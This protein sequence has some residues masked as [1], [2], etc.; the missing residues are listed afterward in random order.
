VVL[1]SIPIR[2]VKKIDFCPRQWKAEEGRSDRIFPP[3]G[4]CKSTWTC[5]GGI[6]FEV[7]GCDCTEGGEKK[8]EKKQGKKQKTR[9]P[10]K[11]DR[12]EDAQ[13]IRSMFLLVKQQ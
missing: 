2:P 11:D 9:R 12:E 7:Y 1:P 8:Q 13:E 5:G 6:N 10:E 3:R 4:P